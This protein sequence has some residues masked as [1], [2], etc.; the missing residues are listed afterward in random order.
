MSFAVNQFMLMHKEPLNCRQPHFEMRSATDLL[1]KYKYE[2][3]VLS[4]RAALVQRFQNR[5]H[6]HSKY[7]HTYISECN[8][9]RHNIAYRM[10]GTAPKIIIIAFVNR[11]KNEFAARCFFRSP[12]FLT[13]NAH[14]NTFKRPYTQWTCL[15][16]ELDFQ[17]HF[18]SRQFLFLSRQNPFSWVFIWIFHF[19]YYYL[20]KLN[21]E[22]FS[23]F[24]CMFFMCSS[25]FV[26][27]TLYDVRLSLEHHKIYIFTVYGTVSLHACYGDSRFSSHFKM[28]FVSD[29][30]N[31]EH[32]EDPEAHSFHMKTTCRS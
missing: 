6:W 8:K 24:L 10:Q 30:L 2:A 21:S 25:K 1:I 27:R 13:S 16:T 7:P 14:T 29:A 18:Y 17:N 3:A 32:V 9:N 15:C 5:S 11:L 12:L 19:I 28:F 23:F 20:L 31:L 22:W 4:E 26:C